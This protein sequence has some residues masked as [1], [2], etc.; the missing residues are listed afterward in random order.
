MGP[1]GQPSLAGGSAEPHSQVDLLG[2]RIGKRCCEQDASWGEPPTSLQQGRTHTGTRAAH[3][4]LGVYCSRS[5]E[6]ELRGS[7]EKSQILH[8]QLAKTNKR[9][10]INHQLLD[11]VLHREQRPT[12]AE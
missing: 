7:K 1:A 3:A 2:A 10:G 4:S 11:K 12:G 8:A 5:T 9:V 6:V